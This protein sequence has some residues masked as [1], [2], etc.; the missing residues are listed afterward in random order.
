MPRLFL[1]FPLIGTEN[2]SFPAVINSFKFTPTENRDGVYLG[3]SEDQT[4]TDNEEAIEEASNLLTKLLEFITS[5]NWR[6]ISLLTI[7][8]PIQQQNGLSLEW[9]RKH[10]K[11]N[12]IPKIRRARAIL[13]ENGAIAVEDAVLPF[14]EDS[15]DAE[16]VEIL[17]D[18]LAG[19][20]YFREK[21]PQR[22]ESVGWCNS[23]R[24]WADIVGSNT[25]E[26]EEVV[27]SSK[28]AL[29]V[30][31]N[32]KVDDEKFGC[33][34]KL[35]E[36]LQQDVCAIDWINQLLAF[37]RNHGFDDVIRNRSII[38]AQDGYLDRLS[39]L[40]RDR[41]IP[42]RL[43]DIAESLDWS[44]R[45]K[46]RDTRLTVLAEEAGAGDYDADRVV[47]ELVRKLQD[48]ANKPD[49]NF[50]EASTSLF[51]WIVE[52]EEWGSLR[53]FPAFSEDSGSTDLNHYCPKKF[54]I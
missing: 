6:D 31:E 13:A 45:E 41:D 19:I 17:W 14:V 9:I 8:P 11:E 39:C 50:K 40:H 36:L 49:E 54:M 42:E 32:S 3:Q 28:L 29:H 47:K 15:A 51:S 33:I 18:L 34:E 22:N 53:N 25:V 26:F 24:S 7:I 46:L 43:K 48:R 38:L 12:L 4:V 20:T 21:L 27:D 16:G 37:L 52:Q 23:A 1:G 10:L 30:E 2:F 5:H 44:I 35:Q